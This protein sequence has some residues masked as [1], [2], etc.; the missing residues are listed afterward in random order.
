MTVAMEFHP[1]A[2][3]AP[4]HL[5]SPRAAEVLARVPELA[6]D[7]L[8]RPQPGEASLAFLDRL[9][10]GPTPE[11]ALSFAAHALEARHGVWWG[12]ECLLARGTF[13]TQGDREM[14]ELAA[15]WVADPSEVNRLTA[16]RRAMAVERGPGAWIALAAG[17]EGALRG[18]AVATGVLMLLSRI[19]Q[20][21]RRR[22]LAQFAAMAQS[23]ATGD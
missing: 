23:L 16:L 14:L 12:H 10:A 11:E 3:A 13:L 5:R 9:K 2:D 15:Q 8:G 18:R 7:I 19:D 4:L 21:E 6:Q 17:Q 22:W 1:H 20:D